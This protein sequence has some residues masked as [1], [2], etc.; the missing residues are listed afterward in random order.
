M[1]DTKTLPQDEQKFHNLE[2]Q[3]RAL[4]EQ[5]LGQGLLEIDDVIAI[6]LELG[7]AQTEQELKEAVKKVAESYPIIKD[8][9][10]TEEQAKRED[11]HDIVQK[12][13]GTFVLQDAVAAARLSQLAL[14]KGVTLEE[15]F[16]FS[17]EFKDF[18]EK[19]KQK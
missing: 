2:D 15:L 10:V 9:L 16:E 1:E 13:V 14:K 6:T 4:L 17:S 8:V 18:Y 5:R 19:N 12:F 3:I 11:M 7:K